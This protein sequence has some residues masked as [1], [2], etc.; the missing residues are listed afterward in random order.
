V[1]SVV[2]PIKNGGADL[3]RCLDAIGR[4]SVT[5]EVEIV[6]VDSGS[7]DGSVELA[8]SRDARVHEIPPEEFGHGRTRNLGA[9]LARG[10]VL[11]FTSQDAYAAGE[12][13]LSRLVE[14]LEREEVAGTYGRQLP[15]DH[16][17][18][19]ERYFLDFLY[20][21]EPRVQR[22]EGAGEPSFEETLF[23]N[24]SSA[25]RRVTWEEFP[26]ADDLI[27]SEDQEWSRRV[28]RAG[29]EL[30]YVADAA[31]HH[32]HRYS[33]ADA[34]RRFFDSGVSAERSYAAGENGSGALRR[35]GV[36]YARGELQWLWESG[37]RRWIPYAA[38]YELA[39]FTGMQLGRRHRRLPEG[40]KRRFS[41][42]PSYWD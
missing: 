22:L 15:H 23:S 42:L 24:V 34:F 31:V 41:A 13:W 33:V 5:D 26:F 3:A 1:I 35:A 8:R 32:S 12:H 40:L 2:V 14:P 18:P 16:A 36:E 19:P 30:V 6:V 39:K 7:T 10:E 29:Y 17:T 11:V 4:Q 37:R 9:S 25:M 21:P 27:M 28:L 38:V 20:G